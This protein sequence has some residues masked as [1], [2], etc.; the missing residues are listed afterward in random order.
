MDFR[1]P[2]HRDGPG[3]SVR[4]DL[5]EGVTAVDVIDKRDKLAANLRRPLSATWPRRCVP[6]IPAGWSCGSGFGA[7]QAAAGPVAAARR[8]EG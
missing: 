5:P 1:T 8:R 7:E 6:S 3:W 4:L 2:I